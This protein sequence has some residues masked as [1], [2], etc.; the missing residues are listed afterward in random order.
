MTEKLG[1]ACIMDELED[2]T[3]LLSACRGYRHDSFHEPAASFTLG[4]E[5]YLS[6]LLETPIIA[7]FFFLDSRN[8]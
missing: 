7:R 1:N 3:I 4:T 2:I 8:T 5:A 6:P